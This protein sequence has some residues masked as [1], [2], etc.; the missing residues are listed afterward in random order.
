MQIPKQLLIILLT[1]LYLVFT[2]ELFILA[3]DFDTLAA[4]NKNCSIR[5]NN[6]V[7]I[8]CANGYTAIEDTNAFVQ[9]KGPQNASS[10]FMYKQPVTHVYI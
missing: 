7:V 1:Q 10:S 4:S 8:F 5:L 3:S 2:Q 6:Q 9:I